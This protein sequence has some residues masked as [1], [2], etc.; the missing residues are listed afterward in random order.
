MSGSEELKGR[1]YE[2]KRSGRY[3]VL[4][5]GELIVDRSTEPELDAARALVARGITGKLT[6]LDGKT[7]RPRTIINIEQAAKLT[8]KEGPLRFRP[9]VQNRPN[10]APAGEDRVT[11]TGMTEEAA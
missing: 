5:H 3:S 11:G 2:I 8:V 7:G 1:R 10:R 6:M 4:F 9:Y